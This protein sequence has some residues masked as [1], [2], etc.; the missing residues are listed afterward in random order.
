MR[1]KRGT[2]SKIKYVSVNDLV[3]SDEDITIMIIKK[4]KQRYRTIIK[5]FYKRRMYKGRKDCVPIFG[6]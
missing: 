6:R 3:C 2:R 4:P 5:A 1:S